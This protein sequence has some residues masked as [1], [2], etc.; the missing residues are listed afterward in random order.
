MSCTRKINILSLSLQTYHPS[1]LFCAQEHIVTITQ[2]VAFINIKY[3]SHTATWQ[4]NFSHLSTFS[5]MF[6]SIS[7]HQLHFNT[8]I[9]HTTFPISLRVF[10]AEAHMAAAYA[11]LDWTWCEPSSRFRQWRRSWERRN[12]PCTTRSCRDVDSLTTPTCWCPSARYRCTWTVD[13]QADCEYCSVHPSSTTRLRPPIRTDKL[14][15]SQ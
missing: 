12:D 9:H 6:Y 7:K 15:V 2:Y 14:E 13:A 10:P 8:S 11:P 4:S 3:P 1:S 5:V